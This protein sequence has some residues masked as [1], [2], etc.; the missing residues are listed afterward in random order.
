MHHPKIEELVR[1]DPRYPLEAYEF[2]RAALLHVHELLRQAGT[3]TTADQDHVS[4]RQ[5]LDGIRDLARQEFGLMAPSV[6]R[7]WGV[8]RT[9]DFGEIVFNL[10]D[11]GLVAALPQEDR[12]LFHDV[13][14]LDDV[15]RDYVIDSPEDV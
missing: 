10:I 3:S 1:R 15:T 12:Q 2:V 5:W 14:A 9:D 6:F 11:V 7:T 13:Y 8:H 4:P